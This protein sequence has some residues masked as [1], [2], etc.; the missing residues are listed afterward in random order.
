MKLYTAALITVI[1]LAFS[2]SLYNS[3][4]GKG[5]EK[6]CVK[7][8]IMRYPMTHILKRC[9]QDHDYS[10]DDMIILETEL[11]KY[12]ILAALKKGPLGMYSNDVDNLWHTFILF[13][14]D[15]AE[16]CDQCI[17]YFLHHVPEVDE[18]HNEKER[19][20][21]QNNFRAFIEQYTATFGDE[22]H[23]IWFLDMCE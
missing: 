21:T 13:T 20:N 2:P 1:T 10:A 22:V 5:I 6:D 4:F 18:D 15:Y 9:Q 14:Q 3:F 11:K 12:F 16:F 23:P 8:T 17:G 19:E 7:D